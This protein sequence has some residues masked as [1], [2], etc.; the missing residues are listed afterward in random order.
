VEGVTDREDIQQLIDSFE[1]RRLQLMNAN[2]FDCEGL[3]LPTPSGDTYLM[4]GG[5]GQPAQ[6]LI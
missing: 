1:A 2:G 3:R 4:V 6:L 5:E